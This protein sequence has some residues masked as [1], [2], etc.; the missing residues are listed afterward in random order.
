MSAKIEQVLKTGA[1]EISDQEDELV[2]DGDALLE[3][4]W[5]SCTFQRLK[6]LNLSEQLRELLIERLSLDSY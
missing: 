1:K 3:Q 4:C 6:I 5:E 2:L